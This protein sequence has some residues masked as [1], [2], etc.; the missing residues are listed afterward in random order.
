M[1]TAGVEQ[2]VVAGVDVLQTVQTRS[3]RHGHS[4]W[5]QH[6]R[7]VTQNLGLVAIMDS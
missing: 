6:A 2:L 7:S 5:F 3:Q 1:P 4:Q